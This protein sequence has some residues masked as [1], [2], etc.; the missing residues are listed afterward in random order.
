MK[1]LL[2]TSTATNRPYSDFFKFCNKSLELEIKMFYRKK[3]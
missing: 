3:V 1:L 2:G